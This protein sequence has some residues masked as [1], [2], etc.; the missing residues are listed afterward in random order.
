M[1]LFIY[2]D[3]LDILKDVIY[4]VKENVI[5]LEKEKLIDK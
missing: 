3:I 4:L 2:L 1:F 5:Y